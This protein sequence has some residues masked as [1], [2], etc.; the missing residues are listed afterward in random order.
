MRRNLIVVLL[1][2]AGLGASAPAGATGALE[3][4]FASA[5]VNDP[6]YRAARHERDAA[7]YGVP[8]A[9]AGLLPSLSLSAGRSSSRGWRD[10]SGAPGGSVRQDLDY[11][12][13]VV[14]LSLRAPLLNF[15]A[16]ARYRQSKFQLA[17]AEAQFESN[18]LQ[19]ADRLT[20]AYFQRL[21]SDEVVAL[22]V[23]QL[24]AAREQLR[25]AEHR[26]GGGEGTRVDIADAAASAHLAEAQLLE[27]Q[28]QAQVAQRGLNNITGEARL[29]LVVPAED[30]SPPPLLPEGLEQWLLAAT[31]N[32]PALRARQEAL[33][34]AALE[35]QRN[36]A[37]HAPRIDLVASASASENESISTLNQE[38]RL[39]TIG[40]QLTLPLFSGGGV[41]AATDQ[42]IA[43]R[44]RALA[45]RDAELAALQLEI[46]RQYRAVASGAE[47][48][49]AYAN[50]IDASEVALEGSRRQLSAGLATTADVLNAS[51]Q[52]FLTKRDMAQARYEYLLARLRLQAAAGTDVDE[53]IA[54]IEQFLGPPG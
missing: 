20:T 9:R 38:T 34:V 10:I 15:E 33:E 3:R 12:S 1:M 21:L 41:N 36:R 32:S 39:Y 35:I 6:Q 53:I 37:G 29:P 26:F 46:E 31:T 48:V 45:E 13:P 2:L 49:L 44:S 28:D 52:V 11:R 14:Q 40:V 7:G 24:D 5:Q 8:L 43:L 23:A 42:A 27:A 51:R 19:L 17:Q 4:A 50:A 30:F 18:R 25:L 22:A 16:I 47:R 54:D